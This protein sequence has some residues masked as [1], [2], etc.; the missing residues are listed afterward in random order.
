MGIFRYLSAECQ[1][2]NSS[3]NTS[4]FY[5]YVSLNVMLCFL[6][7]PMAFLIVLFLYT[8]YLPASTLSDAIFYSSSKR[9]SLVTRRL[10]LIRTGSDEGPQEG[11]PI[12][13]SRTK[14]SLNHVIPTAVLAQSRSWSGH[15]FFQAPY[16]DEKSHFQLDVNSH[17]KSEH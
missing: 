12:P 13:P 9:Q 15:N 7:A 8:L 2:I 16:L 3:I 11:S 6:V 14:F 1:H 10:F 17:C 4:P 5:S